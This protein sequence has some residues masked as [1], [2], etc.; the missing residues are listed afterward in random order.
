MP[1]TPTMSARANRAVDSLDVFVQERD[2]MF[3]G[4]QGASS[5]RAAIGKLA[6]SQGWEG[7]V[8]GP[9]RKPQN[10]D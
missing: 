10:A 1:V 3:T 9:N 8:P 6:R 7:R 5:G 4:R 2:R